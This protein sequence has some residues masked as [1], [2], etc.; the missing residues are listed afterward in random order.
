[1]GSGSNFEL[2]C[3]PEGPDSFNK[4]VGGALRVSGATVV[5]SEILI[6]RAVFQHV[7]DGA[8]HCC[9]N[10]DN[11]FL[12]TEAWRET[13]ISGSHAGALHFCR[14]QRSLHQDWLQP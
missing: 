13:Q 9:C 11:R 3:K 12:M 2:D 8:Q 7:I 10:R 14:R 4:V 5:G 6:E 1:M